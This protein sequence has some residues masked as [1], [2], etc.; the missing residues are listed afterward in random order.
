[1]P[2]MRNT[3]KARLVGIAIAEY[4]FKAFM[5]PGNAGPNFRWSNF[6]EIAKKFGRTSMFMSFSPNTRN[7]EQ[8]ELI[9]SAAA[10]K[11]AIELMAE[12]GI[13]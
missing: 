13:H 2:R 10:E 8:L 5:E 3:E 7:M 11:R 9:S 6:P 4:N 1:M 12:H